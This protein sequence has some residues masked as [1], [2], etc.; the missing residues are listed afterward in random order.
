MGAAEQQ[1]LIDYLNTGHGIYIEG[2]NFG[3][4]H[5][6]T[7]FFNY[8]GCALDADSTANIGTLNGI[9]ST[10]TSGMS[11]YFTMHE[12]ANMSVDA[13]SA[14]T[15]MNIFTSDGSYNRAVIS[16]GGGDYRTICST[17]VLGGL[18][19]GT[20]TRAELLDI[21]LN[22]LLEP[23]TGTQ[24][25]FLPM[26][27]KL[28][29]NYPNPFNPTTT[30]SFSTAENAENAEL[31]IYNIRGQKVRTLISNQLSAG[32]HS[33]IWNGRDSNGN[34]VGSGIYFYKLKAGD[35]ISTKKMI[36]LK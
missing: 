15:G 33:I 3:A 4:D 30:I 29:G 12:D 7:D 16:D 13:I 24:N 19:N 10:L 22:F 11:Y 23:V 28:K 8:F 36:L 35:Y 25:D 14:T 26:I 34:R 21:Y 18:I 32:D 17:P 1:I 27:M 20:N 5:T 31:A 2:S 6:G 9:P